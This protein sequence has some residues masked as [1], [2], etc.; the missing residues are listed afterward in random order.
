MSDKDTILVNTADTTVTRRGVGPREL[1]VEVLA[2]NVNL[3]LSQI[4][5]VL[6]KAPDEVAG[7]KFQ[8]TEFTVSA[9]ISAK[10]GLVL[11]GT[12]VEAAGKGGLT[13]K[14]VRIPAAS[15]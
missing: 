14:F 8:F 1:K 13:F 15:A 6:E 11:M 4:E 5:G 7:G 9:E 10:G 12:G 3:F 2:E